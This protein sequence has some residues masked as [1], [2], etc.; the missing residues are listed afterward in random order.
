MAASYMD[1]DNLYFEKK[2]ASTLMVSATTG[3]RLLSSMVSIY[4]F[5]FYAITGV[6]QAIL[7]FHILILHG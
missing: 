2:L 4:K 7:N 1:R 6:E 3:C 5:P